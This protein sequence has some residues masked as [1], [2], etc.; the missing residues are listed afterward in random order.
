MSSNAFL[1]A[2]LAGTSLSPLAAQI[3]DEPS[4][5]PAAATPPG[6]A[7]GA[8]AGE[9][10][11]DHEDEEG[12]EI[13]VTGQAPRGSVIGDARPEVT[14]DRREIRAYGAGSLGE[15]IGALAPQT[16]SGRGR[17]DG[18]P[19]VLLNGRRISG[20]REIRDIP[21]EAVERVEVLP[22]E[23]ALRYGYRADQRVVNVVLRRRFRAVTA[24]SS[25]GFATAGGRSSYGA[26]LNL[27]RIDPAGRWSV[28]AEYSHSAPLFESERDVVQ[29]APPR[30]FDLLGNVASAP[31][32]AAAE[33]DPALSA[34]VGE[35]VTVAGVP[36]AAADGPPSLADFAAS[37]NRPNVTD[38]GRFRTLLP[39][40]DQVE[41]GGTINRFVFGDLS[42]T[43]N[44]RLE[45]SESESRLGLPTVTLIVPEGNPF[46]PFGRDVTL[47]RLHDASGPLTRR[48]SART[49]HLGLTLNGDLQPWRWTF[50]A[51][52]DQIRNVTRTDTGL[53][54]AAL[55]ARTDA[56]D[57][58]VNPFGGFPE[59]LL[60][61]RPDD[62]SRA[63]G[64]SA[65][66]Q[67]VFNG[68]LVRLP[69]GRVAASVRA[70]VET[71]ALDSRAVRAG[72][73]RAS[74]VSRDRAAAQAS[75]D[76]PVASR[77][78]GFLSGLGNL[79]VNLNG[80]VEQLSDFGTLTTLGYGARWE[81]VPEL[82]FAVSV[83]E[84]DGAPTMQQLGN[85]AVLTPNVRVF[86]FTRGETVDVTRIEGGNP[87]L[88]AD[89][90]RVL[91]LRLTARPLDETDLSIVANYTRTRIRDAIAA[92]PTATP[93]I[94]AAFADRFVRDGDGR[95]LQIDAR[96]V[97]FARADSEELRWGVNFSRPIGPQGPTP[98][99]R[100]AW[101]ERMRER[102]EGGGVEGSSPPD[103]AG[104]GRRG[105]GQGFGRGGFGRF[106][107]GG[108]GRLQ[109]SLYHSW[110][111]TDEIL[112]RPGVPVLDLLDGSAVGNRGGRP[113]H[114][115]EFQ[116]RVF[117]SGF[118][119]QLGA[120]WQSG[121]VVRGRPDGAGAVAGELRFSDLAIFNLRL[122]AELGRQ[123]ALVERF[124]FFRGARF[125]LSVDNLFDSRLQVRDAAGATPLGYQP[126]Y[127]DP[128][129]RSVRL[130]LRKQ[131]FSRPNRAGFG[132][133]R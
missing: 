54:P 101:R 108:G 48:S 128:L 26:D 67:A 53:D 5:E 3:P 29:S 35:S 68:P 41:L 2:L 49:G 23:V 63:T 105:G 89:N 98:E 122:F 100:A 107:G 84:E 9:E 131:F 85:P 102:R 113:R 27:L 7:A 126:D 70:G 38:L 97:N 111:F 62:R 28:D 69:A 80:E 50:T 117:L 125:S 25:A 99:Q 8:A 44:A 124:P 110:R 55:Q 91:N 83:T 37:A 58:A 127:L 46:S 93:E 15:L 112:I 36:A 33:I 92:F 24:E 39:E 61:A 133:T 104:E 81:P 19:V 47:F 45:L 95:L 82:D 86:D 51:N 115:L 75:L 30:P 130:T 31:F 73:E 20:F 116:A 43:L 17:G 32:A 57:P 71:R 94:E 118:G 65:D 66:A 16:R 72:V 96:P 60:A 21:P 10:L 77:R 74:D 13:V 129:G 87:D 114:E 14:L 56:G 6:E 34:L 42:A 76:I 22:E 78:A 40:T 121:T 90:R 132:R 11:D 64:I 12:E 119:A 52:L 18:G 123:R 106:G 109:L 88:V 4:A 103:R 120:N 1:F 79:S 59:G